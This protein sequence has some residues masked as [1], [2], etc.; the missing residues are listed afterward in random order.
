MASGSCVPHQQVEHMAAPTK[1]ALH[2]ETPCQRRAV[3]TW[4]KADIRRGH[5][6]GDRSAEPFRRVVQYLI[7]RRARRAAAMRPVMLPSF[8][9]VVKN[10]ENIDQFTIG[11]R[12]VDDDVRELDEFARLVIATRAPDMGKTRSG[13]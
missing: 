7:P 1:P 2:Q 8:L 9:A 11:M 5:A 4:R 10:G 12:L 3:H 13:Q 6:I